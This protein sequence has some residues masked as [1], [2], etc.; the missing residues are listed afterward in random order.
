[1]RSLSCFLLL[2]CVLPASVSA[3]MWNGQDTLYGNEWIDFSKTYFKIKVAE[4]GIYRVN[5]QILADAGFPLDQVPADQF[6]LYAYGRQVAIFS[7]T[8]GLFAPG[9]FFEFYGEKNRDEV[10]RFL[11]EQPEE[12]NLSSQISLFNDTC[13]YYLGWDASVPPLRFSVL[14][15]DL[16]NLPPKELWCWS[17][18]QIAYFQRHLKRRITEEITFS[19]FNGEGFGRALNLNTTVPLP[20][21]KL[22]AAGPPARVRI[23]YACD[24]G[25][26]EQMVSVNDSLFFTDQFTGWKVVEQTFEAPNSLLTGTSRIEVETALGGSDR[27]VVSGGSIRYSRQFAFENAASAFF[28]LDSSS[29]SKYLEIQAFNLNAG[30]PVLYD[31]TNSTRLVTTTAG[32]LAKAKLPPDSHPVRRFLLVN[33][34]DGVKTVSEIASVQFHDFRPDD[35]EFV[36]LSNPALYAD[37]VS[38]GANHV[39]EYA[40]Y[41]E[42]P[43]GGNFKTTVVDVN[44]LYEQF[45]YGVR[46]HPIAVRNFCHYIKKHWSNPEYLFIIGKGLDY[47]LFRDPAVQTALADSLFFVPTFGA[48]GADMLFVMQ[49]SEVSEPIFPVGRIA[50]TRPVEIR[51]Y[52]DKVIEHEQQLQ[53]APQTIAG[54]QRFKKALHLSGGLLSES[55]TIKDFTQQMAGTL[56]NGRLG[57]EVTTF[58]KTS[59]DPVQQSAYEKILGTV[60]DG[61]ALWMIFGH[62]SSNAIDFDI[63]TP[64]V[65][66]NAGRYPAMMVMGC[67]SG[68][69]SNTQQGLGEQFVL[70][71]D[72]GAIAW[73][74]SVNFSEIDALHQYGSRYYE[75][76]GGPDYHSGTGRIMQ[77]TIGSLLG[78]NNSNALT[79]MLHQ[80]LLQGDPAVRLNTPEGPDFTFDPAS[81][82]IE[83]NPVSL[84]S[85]AFTMKFDVL[86]LGENTGA[87]LGLKI[88]Q[89]RP[90]NT[91]TDRLTDTLAGPA[92]RQTVA[93]DFSTATDKAGI[94]RFFLT[95]DPENAVVEQPFSAE[96]NNALTDA[97][98]APGTEVYFY[99]DDVQPLWPLD[100]GIVSTQQ[101]KLLA[102][103]LNS[104]PAVRR[105][106]FELDTSAGFD[107]PGRQFYTLEQRGG[108]LQWQ[109]QG[110]LNDSTVYYWR[111][112]RDSLVNGAVVWHTRS[113][114]VLAGSSPGWNQQH[115]GQWQSNRL[116]NLSVDSLS[117]RF[118]FPDNAGFVSVNVAWRGM[119]R[120]PGL[121]NIHYEG[122][123]GD[124]GWN[125][126]GIQRGV[127]LML[128]EPNGGHVA[129]NPA[130]GPH[131]PDSTASR[132]YYWF[133]TADTLE[134]L[135]LIQFVDN[136]IPNG[137]YVG[138]LAFN[139]P[140]DTIGYAPR[141]WAADSLIAGK[142]LFQV[143]ENQ[144]A[145][146]A[147]QLTQYA[148]APPAYGFIFRKNDPAFT[149][150]D[151]IVYN[152]D[153]AALIRRN[154]TAKWA[155]GYFESPPL[156]PALQWDSLYW[157][158]AAAD[159]ASDQATLSVLGV[160]PE[161][162]DTL[163]AKLAFGQDADLSGISALKFPQIRLRYDASDTLLR[164]ATQLQYLR[165]QFVAVPEGGLDPASV[166]TF[167]RDTLQEG[168]LLRLKT[169][170]KNASDSPFDSLLVRY[171]FENEQGS[172]PVL[173]QKYP[174]L[175]AGDTLDLDLSYDTRGL[176]GA[177]RLLIDVNPTP[178][179][180]ELF[181]FNNVAVQQFYVERD[182]RNPFLDV[183]FDG[184]HILD[185]DLVS[186]EPRIV[187]TL[188]D[189]NPFL[190][191]QDTA[192]FQLSLL[193]P[194]GTTTALDPGGPGFLFFPAG[195]AN[196][197]QKNLARLEWS[198]VFTVDG[199][200]QLRVNGR[201]A[202]GNKAGNLQY[203]VN[204]K[205]ITKSSL[206]NILNYPNPFSNSTCFVYTMTGAEPPA[207]FNLRIMTVSGK[208]VREISGAEFG[209]MW[210]GTHQSSFCWDGRD[211]YGDQL[212]NG[213]Y[214]YQIIAKKADGSDFELFD[215]TAV[216]G[217]FKN[218]I[219]KM[220]LIR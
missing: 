174:P 154:F 112:A 88:E 105:Y 153:S 176:S 57:A 164:T 118:E 51:H 123:T 66:Q 146:K 135:A 29:N 198:P 162:P 213:V 201:D 125:Q 24:L 115:K 93:Y 73:F 71:P 103:T 138:L 26:H 89:R 72:K 70:A 128:Q 68:Q 181:H 147:R 193:Y 47:S 76:L 215:N 74:A 90:D 178:G 79:A 117:G 31:L 59:T 96:L 173:T 50:V 209:P 120:Y 170:F 187:M 168:D 152:P 21:K 41:R 80:N 149:P 34:A 78:A 69:C 49:G 218:G 141:F 44:Q 163:L 42:S 139:R 20:I 197:P 111:I 185:G 33:P 84:E 100:Y 132:F 184:I 83:P 67:F 9:D 212:A 195:T 180:A 28:E 204:F 65:Y 54:K 110:S 39:A 186:P 97:S 159:D 113:F 205:V 32:N 122:S 140:T 188:K 199:Q 99:A 158:T 183:T 10:D 127:L 191:L 143:F 25:D 211:T 18:A 64:D 38:G 27:H 119:N 55:A 101:I 161:L 58:Y 192:A 196:L 36:I 6:R 2:F 137:Y 87:P 165:I 200:Y 82:S 92:W 134:R 130:G 106:L 45:G 160:R 43:A 124:F 86:N 16:T 155:Q 14:N 177:Q 129:P 166:Y 60:N 150:I 12:Q 190:A 210:A 61:V 175:A 203:T 5:Y 62:S 75:L 217:Y 48:P 172:G 23:R 94:N 169:A 194:D 30:A 157:N 77:H 56:A 121:Q 189:E 98:G 156:G 15:N 131:N 214:F 114:T 35:A 46:Y 11:F 206:S 133:N 63:G 182:Q 3:Q 219:G 116:V 109:P 7:S 91:L 216:D 142:N 202:S 17:E 52:L 104:S 144:G 107:S 4:D 81:F 102:S 207:Y 136:E 40:A 171:R 85:G 179:Q 22:Y 167:Y 95:L 145:K 1:M 220:V 13:A 126:E 108:L 19:W 53:T 148:A 37:P 208:V 8:D 151:T